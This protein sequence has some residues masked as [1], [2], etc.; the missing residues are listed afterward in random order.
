MSD[1]GKPSS[2]PLLL[3]IASQDVIIQVLIGALLQTPF[4][5]GRCPLLFLFDRFD[6]I[7]Y[8]KYRVESKVT[9]EAYHERL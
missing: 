9:K 8:N 5:A 2:L 4:E 7:R 3:I 1:E 6:Y